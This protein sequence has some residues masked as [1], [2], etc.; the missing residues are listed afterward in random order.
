M[1]RCRPHPAALA[2]LAL[3]LASAATTHGTYVS[4]MSELR[5]SAATVQMSYNPAQIIPGRYASGMVG[6]GNFIS[7][8]DMG[9]RMCR[10]FIDGAAHGAAL[11]YNGTFMLHVLLHYNAFGGISRVKG[12]VTVQPLQVVAATDLNAS[13]STHHPPPPPPIKRLHDVQFDPAIVLTTPDNHT[14]FHI[15]GTATFPFVSWCAI[16]V[17]SSEIVTN[18]MAAL[19]QVDSSSQLALHSP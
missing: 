10:L 4:Y 15:N 6:D 7:S 9:V 8:A 17:V 1:V 18:A 5:R 19:P 2:L 3:L 14:T 11:G 12:T 13:S 16:R